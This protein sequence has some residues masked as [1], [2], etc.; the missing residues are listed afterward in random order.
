MKKLSKKTLRKSWLKWFLGNLSSMSF[1]WLAAFG[2]ADAMTP[3]IKELYDDKEEQIK[4][5]KRNSTFYNTEPQ[6]GTI[7]NGVIC[8]LE[9]EK[10]NGADIDDEVINGIKIGLMGPLAGIGDAMV[11]GMWVPLLLSIAISLS[12]GGSILGPIFYIVTYITSVTIA[13]YYLFFKGYQLG[14][15]SIDII[16]GEAAKKVREAFNLLGAIVV[17]GVAA[18]Y[19]NISTTLQIATGDD[20]APVIVNDILNSIFPKILPLF[21][22]LL[23]WYL[24]SKKKISPLKVMLILVIMAIGGVLIG[25]F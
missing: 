22:V 21:L 23:C 18:S 11:P 13:S 16:T 5:L 7:I 4:A 10:A 9:E 12:N 8:G 20:K 1:Q 19:V 3:V 25:F 2:F 6:L 15:K 24:M 17:G 14:T